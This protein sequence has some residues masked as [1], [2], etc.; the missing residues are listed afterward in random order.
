MPDGKAIA[1]INSITPSN[2]WLQ[3][4]DGTP[5]RQITSFTERTIS[6]FGW[7]RDG[8]RLALA[9]ATITNDIVLFKGLKR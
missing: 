1:Y 8:G 3:P 6:D 5:P 9:R 4:L 2:V 7:S